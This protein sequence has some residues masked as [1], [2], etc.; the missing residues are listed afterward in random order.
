MDDAKYDSKR[1]CELRALRLFGISP[2]GSDARK[3]ASGDPSLCFGISPAG[4]DA[5]KTAQLAQKIR[6]L[7]T[8][9]L[10]QRTHS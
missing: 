6:S 2:A 3:T 7:Y 5:R 1:G 10:S 8:G 9:N 4:S